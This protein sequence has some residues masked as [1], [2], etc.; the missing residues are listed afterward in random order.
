[1]RILLLLAFILATHGAVA[2]EPKQPQIVVSGTATREVKPDTLEWYLSVSHLGVDLTEV[3]SRH[4]KTVSEVIEMLIQSDVEEDDIQT[5]RMQFGENWIYRN[6]SRILEGYRATTGVSFETRSPDSYS[7]LWMKLA[8]IDG[9]SVGNVA[10]EHSKRIEIRDEIRAEALLAA[11]SKAQAMAA[12]LGSTVGSPL[13]IEDEPQ[14]NWAQSN[15]VVTAA[16][17]RGV[18]QE[19]SGGISLGTISIQATVRVTFELKN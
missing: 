15:F 11:R 16:G 7:D 2:A 19:G 10:F 18:L 12:A 8:A 1:M 3:A 9:V 13:L 4:S 17:E 5:S 14:A 6:S